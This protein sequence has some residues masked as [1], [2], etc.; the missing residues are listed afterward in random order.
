[1][2]LIEKYDNSNIIS[3]VNYANKLVGKTINN[4][5]V[6]SPYDNTFKTKDKGSI[7]K[8][9]EKH[10][11]NIEPNSSPLPDFDK[12]S[13]ELKIIPLIQ[14]KTKIAVKE[15]TKICSIDYKKL[16]LET[17]DNSHAKE[18]LNKVL[19]IYY[20]YDKDNIRNSLIK[21]IDLWELNQGNNEFIIKYD[22][23]NVQQKVKDG[24]AHELSES[25]CK[26]LAPARS[27]SG[28]KDKNG[29][30]K[31]LVIQPIQKYR[32]DAL[33]RSFALKQSF[34]NQRWN[35]LN[36][37]IKYESIIDSLH[38][39]EFDKFEDV[40]LKNINK[41]EGKSIQ[42]LSNIFSLK[43]S[44]RSKNQ[45]AT[46]IKKSIGFKSVKSTIKEFE[47]LGIMVKTIKVRKN[48][49]YPFEAISFQTMKL[50][51]LIEENWEESTFK[52]YINK[53]LFVPVYSENKDSTLGE[54]Y[55]GKS[56]FWSPSIEE[57]SIIEREWNQYKSEVAN[58]QC[59]VHEV[60]INSK[61]G[62]KEVSEL[63]KESE[64]TAIHMRPHG[65]D[66][67]DR[68]VDSFGNSIVKQCFWLNKNFIQK[69][70]NENS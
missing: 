37:K 70:L 22:W 21:K 26:V 39:N 47:Q 69:L 16:I 19:F 12:V 34:T 45:I 58:G 25:L 54:K 61:K 13:V 35:E 41:Y 50:K 48:N 28:G 44:T 55:I 51:E 20:L 17:W 7:G 62:F 67:N 6:S 64:T 33:K 29:K 4:I 24:Y 60:V 27:G 59:K 40:I 49:N 38:I 46:I 5:I 11:F 18:K 68:D 53:I 66:S 14:Q 9:I 65:R 57:K 56:F 43:I 36:K 3:I 10:W 31:D 23:L 15:R 63:S 30:L 52:E 32:N 42:E 1:M 2:S 8:I